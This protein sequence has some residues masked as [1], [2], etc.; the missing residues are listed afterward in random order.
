MNHA[1]SCWSSHDKRDKRPHLRKKFLGR[2]V[3]LEIHIE[4]GA[5]RVPHD[6]LY[7]WINERK[8]ALTTKSWQEKGI[9]HWP[10]MPKDMLNFLEKYR[11]S[12]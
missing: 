4:E 5:F 6:E 3:I 2:S 8:T 11:V 7:A 12:T 9:Y 10:N 1:N